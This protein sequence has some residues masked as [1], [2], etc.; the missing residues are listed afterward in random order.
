MAF[1]DIPRVL[2]LA[3]VLQL[4][5]PHG[6]LNCFGSMMEPCLG[7]HISYLSI[8]YSDDVQI[9]ANIPLWVNLV[10]FVHPQSTRAHSHALFVSK[11]T[12]ILKYCDA[13]SCLFIIFCGR[14]SI[15]F[16]QWGKG[17]VPLEWM[18]SCCLSSLV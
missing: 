6:N 12:S 9:Q 1:S 4:G 8:C 10:T 7:Y 5:F 13:M 3:I 11:C 15:M 2:V 14:S 18:C 17:F 16:S